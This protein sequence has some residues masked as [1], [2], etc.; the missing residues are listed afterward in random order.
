MIG[1]VGYDERRLFDD[2]EKRNLETA[3]AY[4]LRMVFD[5]FSRQSSMIEHMAGDRCRLVIKTLPWQRACSR[6]AVWLAY[7]V[8]IPAGFVPTSPKPFAVLYPARSVDPANFTWL[9]VNVFYPSILT[10]T[11]VAVCRGVSSDV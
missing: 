4:H 7:H 10:G 1:I 8:K 5:N 11:A 2:L 6:P 9:R 3:R